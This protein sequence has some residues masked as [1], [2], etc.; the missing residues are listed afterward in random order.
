LAA[1]PH[2]CSIDGEAPKRVAVAS[3]LFAALE[4]WDGDGDAAPRAR[5]LG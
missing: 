2:S 5:R 1:N 4:L 3:T